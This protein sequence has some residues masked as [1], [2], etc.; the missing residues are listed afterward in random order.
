MKRR[1]KRR[2]CSG[3]IFLLLFGAACL[4]AVIYFRVFHQTDLFKTEG[5]RIMAEEKPV[6]FQAVNIEEGSL[7]DKYYYNTLE[8]EDQTAYQEILQGLRE[9]LE[10]IYIHCDAEDKINLLLQYVLKD[11]PEIFWCEGG[12]NSTLYSSGGSLLE[13][14]TLMRPV[15]TCTGE[16]KEQKQTEID[17]QVKDCL[18]KVP[19]DASDYDK[20]LYVYEY[21]VNT[22]DYE[23]E[24][25]D[26][27]NIYSVFVNKKSVC[28]G[29][30]KAAQY[31]LE[32]LGVFCTYVTG[33]V[34]NQNSHAWNLVQCEGV[35]YYLDTTWGD[36]VYQ[37]AEGEEVPEW[38]NISYDY[39]CCSEEELFRTHQV[40]GDFAFP[41]CES[42]EANYYVVNGMY[43]DNYDSQAILKTMNDVIGNKENPSV[44][45]FSSSE[46]YLTARED[47]FNN[48]IQRAAQNLA[49]I[50][51]L[52]QVQYFYQDAPELNKI[53]IYWQ[54]E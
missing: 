31:L 28:A 27:Q 22:V 51:G 45:K 14:Y 1:K 38:E 50:Y 42:M 13:G 18:S 30:S 5:E 21:I 34:Q 20:I 46:L 52:E 16:V 40:D 15:Y 29:Y 35:Y 48:L 8:E 43:Y 4:S 6:P 44:F 25:E 12:A 39:M 36:P 2:G 33:T 9:V 49:G 54:Y 53:T 19:A 17:I 7:E 3:I 47:I 32:R 10:E 26:N 41:K 37:K 11:F 24:A 23:L